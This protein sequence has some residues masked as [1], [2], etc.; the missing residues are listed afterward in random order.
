M[1]CNF[2]PEG[3]SCREISLL[4]GT[5]CKCLS[6]YSI[7]TLYIYTIKHIHY[8]LKMGGKGKNKSFDASKMDE[9]LDKIISSIADNEDKAKR[10]HND[11]KERLT[12]IEKDVHMCKK[13]E[14]YLCD[15]VYKLKSTV[16][17]LEQSKFDNFLNI[18]GLP[19]VEKDGNQLKA[20][21]YEFVKSIIVPVVS[22]TALISVTR[23]GK[24][25][26]EENHCRP[27]VVECVNK[28]L[29]D[30]ILAKVKTENVNCEMFGTREVLF[31]SE[32]TKVYVGHYLS[33]ANS[34]I[35]YQARK[36]R[37]DGVVKY[38]WIKDGRVLIKKD[39]SSRAFQLSCIE[40]IDRFL[41]KPKTPVIFNSTTRDEDEESDNSSSSEHEEVETDAERPGTSTKNKR[42]R[43]ADVSVDH[44]QRPSKVKR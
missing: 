24:K 22:L 19:E 17:Q 33:R 25:R 2:V 11:I 18:R 32:N 26:E 36:L 28:S 34:T 9:K 12:I 43:E 16:N 31:G 3:V 37:R 4:I 6:A 23:I 14:K 7:N 35:F 5:T 29:K 1:N 8:N 39:E 15:E 42:G 20:G 41:G 38:A 30:A 21:V 44:R 13:R 40:D 27:I 10:R